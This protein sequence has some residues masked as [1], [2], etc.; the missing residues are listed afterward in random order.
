LD[1]ILSYE[2]GS[3]LGFAVPP[4]S[5]RLGDE[6]GGGGGLV[7]PVGCELTHGLVVAGQPVDAALHENETELGVAVL[8]VAV[9][10]LAHGH[11]LLDQ[12]VQIL[13]NFGGE[14]LSLKDAQHLGSGD[15]AHLGDAVVITK[16][17]SD[18]GGGEPLLGELA[19]LL[20]NLFEQCAAG[21]ALAMRTDTLSLNA[22][23]CVIRG[24]SLHRI[25]TSLTSQIPAGTSGHAR[26]SR[27]I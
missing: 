6:G 22:V 15:R 2:S 9:Q 21:M 17:H 8:P 20:L 19:A 18:L 3:V 24:A 13:G 11:G 16:D 25:R 27:N 1:A 5:V 14:A 23:A 26:E 4:S 7:L 10:V 12:L